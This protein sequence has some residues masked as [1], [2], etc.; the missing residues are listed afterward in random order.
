MMCSWIARSPRAISIKY[1]KSFEDDLAAFVRRGSN[2][3]LRVQYELFPNIKRVWSKDGSAW[4]YLGD[5][6]LRAGGRINRTLAAGVYDVDLL[7]HRFKWRTYC[8]GLSFPD[9]PR[10]VRE[11]T[12]EYRYQFCVSCSKA[13][14][15]MCS[16]CGQYYSCGAPECKKKAPGSCTSPFVV[17]PERHVDLS[18]G[19]LEAATCR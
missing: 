4:Y 17:Q 5:V 15:A 12:Q 8:S 2:P 13:M 6:D 11:A 7:T 9:E 16:R 1:V 14:T 3:I 19:A 18:M 10:Y